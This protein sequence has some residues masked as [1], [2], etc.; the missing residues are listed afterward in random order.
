VELSYA[1]TWMVGFGALFGVVMS[2]PQV[3][4]GIRGW[5]YVNLALLAVIGLGQFKGWQ[6]VG[7]LGFLLWLA[8]IVLP[9][10]ANRRAQEA[11]HRQQ[12]D[13]AALWARIVG[14]LHPFDGHREEARILVSQSHFDAGRLDPAKGALYPLLKTPSWSERAKMELLRFDRRWHEIVAHAKAQAVGTRD[15]RLAPLYLRAFGEVG[16][17]E[18]MWTMYGQIP[19]LLAEQPTVRLHMAIYSGLPELTEL[20][21][22]R[23]LRALPSDYADLIRATALYTNGRKSEAEQLLARIVKH[24][25]AGALHAGQRL[26]HPLALANT[27]A[28]SA[29]I[30]RA[31]VDFGRSVRDQAF[32]VQP[33][34]VPRRAWVTM[35][36]VAAQVMV[37]LWGLPGGASDPENLI[38]LGALVLPSEL[39]DGGIAWRIVAAGFLHLGTTHLLMNCLGLWMLGGQVEQ[40][41]GA[42]GMLAIFLISSI[43]SFGFAAS[44]IHATVSEPRIFLGASSGV[45]GL[46]GAIGMFFATGYFR[47]R[48]KALGRRVLLVLAVVLA[49]L[50]FDYFTPIVSSMLHLTGLLIG[51]VTAIP[52][53]VR[54]WRARIARG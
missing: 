27:E 21:L 30:Q 3:R 33:L 5:F 19:P 20:L 2:I 38:K 49:Q 47:Y 22:A 54:S 43:G 26:A 18:A 15:L 24:G 28:L 44:F 41:F 14:V 8:L 50:V 9:G 17:L 4:I 53:S 48:R 25:T 10:A 37:F 46:V 13:R 23:Y 7:Y 16:D 12:L 31:I 52:L 35:A 32:H 34:D 6:D 42:L 11:I 45:L 29:P 51:A 36:L 1:L 39:T 40:L